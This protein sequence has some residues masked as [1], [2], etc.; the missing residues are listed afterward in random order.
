M[1]VRPHVTQNNRN[2][3]S[4]IDPRT[5]RHPCYAMSQQKRSLIERT[6]DWM[7]AVAGLR[8][9]KLRGLLKVDWLF[10]LTA[11][12]SNLW[13]I[14]KLKTVERMCCKIADSRQFDT[15]LFFS[16][17]NSDAVFTNS[18]QS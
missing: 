6:F 11:A 8:K 9:V 5:T 2:R 10:V 18:S 17:I 7:K 15:F 16:K 14:P 12:A 3:P 4:T 13:W 1:D